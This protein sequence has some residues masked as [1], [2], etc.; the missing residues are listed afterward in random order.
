MRRQ[1]QYSVSDVECYWLVRVETFRTLS[2]ATSPQLLKRD[3]SNVF[4]PGGIGTGMLPE[5]PVAMLDIEGE[6]SVQFGGL[7]VATVPRWLTGIL[8]G[9]YQYREGS[10]NLG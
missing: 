3:F 8:D 7:K 10:W 1:E 5:L 6:Q 4:P 2:K 9:T